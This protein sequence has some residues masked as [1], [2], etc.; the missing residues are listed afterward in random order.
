M[1]LISLADG[2]TACTLVIITLVVVVQHTT[3]CSDHC[4]LLLLLLPFDSAAAA[5]VGLAPLC[6]TPT[7][8][9]GLHGSTAPGGNDAPQDNTP[10]CGMCDSSGDAAAAR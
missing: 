7:E 4:T 8:G 3:S 9:G 1:L 5:A 2:I 10:G 6:R